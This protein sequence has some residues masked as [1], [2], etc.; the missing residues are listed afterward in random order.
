M[1]YEAIIFDLDGTLVDSLPDIANAMN[2]VL[3]RYDLPQYDVKEYKFF[4]GEGIKNLV[5]KALPKDNRNEQAVGKFL[6]EMV[7]EYGKHCLDKTSPYEGIE[8]LL[9]ELKGRK[10]KLA[11]FSNKVD[12]LTNII[13]SELFVKWDFNEVLGFKEGIPR[14]PDPA[15]AIYISEKLGI[16]PNKIIFVGDTGIDMKTAKEAGM[17]AVGVAW[18][19]RDVEEL[20]ESGADK[21]ISN[22]IELIKIL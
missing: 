5:Y 12:E 9:D 4:I 22:P 18:G 3:L 16:S 13:V 11:V 7:E 20:K 10:L 2:Q 14:K 6:G 1:K 17:C 15:G 19:Y 8:Q 21:I